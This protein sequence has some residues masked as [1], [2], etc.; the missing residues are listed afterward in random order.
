[1]G[2]SASETSMDTSSTPSS[3]KKTGSGTRSGSEQP[4]P[5]TSPSPVLLPT[6]TFTEQDIQNM[7]KMGFPRDRSIEELRKFNGDVNQAVAGMFAK[8]LS[9]S[10]NKRK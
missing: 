1:M 6:D 8:S 5:A 9:D 3:D 10:F 4:Q 7:V 2:K